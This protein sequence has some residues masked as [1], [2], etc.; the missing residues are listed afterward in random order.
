VPLALLVVV[1]AGIAWVAAA[2]RGLVDPHSGLVRDG[3]PDE[4]RLQ[5]LPSAVRLILAHPWTGVGRGAFRDV[6]PRFDTAG[7]TPIHPHA[8]LGAIDVLADHGLIMGG[9]TLLVVAGILGTLVRDALQ[10]RTGPAPVAAL[11][12]LLVHEGADFSLATGSVSL[13]ALLVLALALP[14]RRGLTNRRRLALVPVTLL[15]IA[16]FVLPGLPHGSVRRCIQSGVDQVA[17]S[18]LTWL[19]FATEESPWHPSSFPL[20]LEVGIGLGRQG[21][22]RGALTWLNRAQ[23]LAPRHPEPHLW[24]ART[25][26][27]VGALG[28]ATG[29]FRRAMEGDWTYRARPI[30]EEAA[31]TL[32]P[33]WDLSTLVPADRP[34]GAADLALWLGELGDP[35]GHTLAGIAWTGAP[36]YPVS[37]LVRAMALAAG[38]ELDGSRALVADLLQDQAVPLPLR[39]R[40]AAVLG[41]LADEGAELAAMRAITDQGQDPGPAAWLTI[42]ELEL[43]RGREPSARVALRRARAHPL[44]AGRVRT[45]VLTALLEARGGRQEAAVELLGEARGLAAGDLE[46]TWLVCHSYAEI[47]E[48]AAA[49]ALATHVLELSPTHSAARALLAD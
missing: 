6:F 4:P 47:G 24:T 35:R 29:E 8:E 10:G 45:L 21:D 25:L 41:D 28:Q 7:G 18:D 23:L 22:I 43:A 40:A 49:R 14:P 38:G 12:G 27:A 31:R 30:L 33:D 36:G 11:L 46:S 20:A 13:S 44:V 15:A 17:R 48:R 34:E 2:S 3:L 1:G 19:E 16:L 32:P 39:I 37:R 26:R 42:A 5:G 9:L